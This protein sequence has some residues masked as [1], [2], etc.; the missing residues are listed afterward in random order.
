VPD[1]KEGIIDQLRKGATQD[2]LLLRN[3]PPKWWGGAR[4]DSP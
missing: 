3:K 2:M 1:G 4:V